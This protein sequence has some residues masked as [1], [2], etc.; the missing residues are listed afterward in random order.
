V[1]FLEHEPEEIMV[2]T[3]ARNYRSEDIRQSKK[4]WELDLC[5]V[6]LLSD[7]TERALGVWFAGDTPPSTDGTS[8]STPRRIGSECRLCGIVD[9]AEVSL[10]ALGDL[11]RCKTYMFINSYLE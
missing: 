2:L 10:S 9:R 3:H 8:Q 11:A 7:A 1:T 4:R 6:P 5:I